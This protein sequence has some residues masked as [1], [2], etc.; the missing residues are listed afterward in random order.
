MGATE[1]KSIEAK[2]FVPARDFEL[3][4]RFYQSIGFTLVWSTPGLACFK[5]DKSLFL[6]QNFYVKEHAD[7]FKMHL[8]VENVD[9]WWKHV[10]TAAAPFGI[11]VEPP[12]DRSWGMRDFPLID[13]SGVLWRIGQ[14]TAEKAG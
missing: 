14:P 13:P 1:L 9:E 7:N 5:H 6:L 12:E 11:T 4:K 2:A 8:W 10:S 3:S